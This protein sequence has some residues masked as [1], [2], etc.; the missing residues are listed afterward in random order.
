[1]TNSKPDPSSSRAVLQ[2]LVA[3]AITLLIM[4]VVLFVPAGTLDW[5]RGWW[6]CA[7]FLAATL[8]AVSW[9]TDMPLSPDHMATLACWVVNLSR[10]SVPVPRLMASSTASVVLRL[11]LRAPMTMG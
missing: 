7:A 8:I 10:N 1:M 11:L 2:S 4:A 9:M 6:F 5:P 3:L